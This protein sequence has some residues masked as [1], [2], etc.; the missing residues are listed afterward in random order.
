MTRLENTNS[1]TILSTLMIAGAILLSIPSGYSQEKFPNIQSCGLDAWANIKDT[2]SLALGTPQDK[3]LGNNAK[4]I[5]DLVRSKGVAHT[6]MM[7][8]AKY[9]QCSREL[10]LDP[11][12]KYTET[13]HNFIGC[14]LGSANRYLILMAI[15]ERKSVAETKNKF[16]ENYHPTIDALYHNAAEQGFANAVNISASTTLECIAEATRKLRSR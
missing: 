11:K 2:Q 8:F 14:S 10:N 4:V 3:L 9:G 15:E 12:A 7:I 16:S 5:A 1:C 13:D 6:L